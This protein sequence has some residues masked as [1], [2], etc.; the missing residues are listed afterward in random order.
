MKQKREREEPCDV[1][2]H[3]HDYLAGE[4]C[5]ICGHRLDVPG[6]MAAAA[7]PAVKPPS[8]FP[9][10]VVPGFLY[11]GSYDH[12]SRHEILKTFGVT[13]ILNTVPTCQALYKNS[14]TYHTVTASPPPLDE[15]YSFLDEVQ[16]QGGKVLV[17]CMSGL[18]RSAVVV[19]YY[20]M[21][22][23]TWRLSE[24]YQWVKDRRPQVA[25]TRDDAA[26]LQQAELQVLGPNASGFQVPLG[27]Q[28][29]GGGGGGGGGGGQHQ[30]ASGPFGWTALGG[31]QAFGGGG[32]APPPAGVQ[33]LQPGQQ[34]ALNFFGGAPAQGGAFVFGAAQQQQQQQQQQSVDAEG[35]MLE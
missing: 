4:P 33:P 32:T 12:A 30:G 16:Q 24:A 9:S 28:P 22:R 20:L 17:H 23:N 3:Y 27:Q 35:D 11:L 19:M 25:I 26:R 5:S 18:S 21:R 7:P 31:V 34:P 14:F 13:H 6:G 15:C 29:A 8:A 10:E 1:C 2:G